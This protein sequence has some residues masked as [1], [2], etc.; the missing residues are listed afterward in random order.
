MTLTCTFEGGS[1]REVL[2]PFE[3]PLVRYDELKPR[4]LEM[5]AIAR[6]QLGM[7]IVFSTSIALQTN[8]LNAD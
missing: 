1:T 5:N 4:M 8:N 7:V 6:E 2:I 3:P